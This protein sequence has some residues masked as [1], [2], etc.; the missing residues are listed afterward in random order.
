[1]LD[2]CRRKYF[3]KF[4]QSALTEIMNIHPSAFNL[5]NL[6]AFNPEEKNGSPILRSRSFFWIIKMLIHSPSEV[7]SQADIKHHLGKSR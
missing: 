7:V 4:R 5:M 3:I 2:R 1:M 6:I